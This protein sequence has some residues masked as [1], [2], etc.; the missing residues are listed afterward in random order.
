MRLHFSIGC[1]DCLG[2][3]DF[4][5]VSNSAEFRCFLL[6]MCIDAPES[7]TNSLS[8]GSILDSARKHRSLESEKKVALCFSFVCRIFLASSHAASRAHRYCHSVSS[9]D[10][11]SNFWNV[12]AALMRIPQANCSTRWFFVPHVSVTQYRWGKLNTWDWL[13]YC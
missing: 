8:F 4:V 3:H 11:S 6:I 9:W 1:Y 7:T 5:T 12:G 13:Q 10:R 2:L